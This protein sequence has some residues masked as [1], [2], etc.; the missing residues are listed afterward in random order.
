MLVCMT[1][2]RPI[3]FA[4]GGWCH[5]EDSGCASLVIAWLPHLEDDSEEAAPPSRNPDAP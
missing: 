4:K 1:C 2:A 3:V 5:R